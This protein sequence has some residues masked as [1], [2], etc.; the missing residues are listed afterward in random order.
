MRVTTR[1]LAT[2]S[3][4]ALTVVGTAACG[5]SS[6]G[7]NGGGASAASG[8]SITVRGC[9]PQNPLIAGNTSEVCGGNVL[10]AVTAKLVHYNSDTAAPEMD[11]A[12]SID[13]K[14]NKVFTVTLQKGRTFSDG[15]PVTAH[16]FV[17]AWNYTAYGPNAQ[18][19]GYFFEPIAGY[20]KLQC[21]DEKCAK[22]PATTK[23]SGLK[24]IDDTHFTITTAQP[25]S[26]LKVRLGYSA[27]AP[28]PDAFLKNPTAASF[29]K[30]PIGAGPYK[31]TEDSATQIVLQKN[32][33]YTGKYA[34]K[35][36][37][38]TFKIYNDASAAYKDLQANQL[39]FTDIIPTDQL[40]GD[41]WKATLGDR[42]VVAKSGLFQEL[43]FSP[44]DPQLK[45][46]YA[47][48]KALAMDIDRD[49][50][51]KQIFNG[52]R[53]PA[54]GWVSPVVDG[55][56]DGACGDT[57]HYD[58]DK[59]KAAYTAA[60]GY[61]GTMQISVNGDGGH[62]DWAQAVCNGWINDLGMKCVVNLTPDFATLRKQIQGGELKGTFRGGWQMDYPSI[63]NFLTPI[64]AKGAASND[65]KYDNPAFDKKLA[66]AAAA[67]DPAQANADYQ[68][69]EDMLAEQ[70]PTIPLWNAATPCAWSTHVSNVKVTPFGTL[71]LSSITVKG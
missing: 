47:L 4:A 56:K 59:A 70:M 25:V 66:E 11:L 36:D 29:G 71:D 13:T 67:T 58:K 18:Q 27:F 57:C 10:E 30:M 49:T 9:T 20:D 38:V 61:N 17:D 8:G 54:D 3:V 34:G 33:K 46:N 35:V 53:T 14:D 24:V 43:T 62:K 2:V 21:A 16:N 37:Q 51:T 23:M 41:N 28:Q 22:K 15:T 48:R 64:Y 7:S 55:F 31:V 26:N 69:A 68:A 45:T 50:I 60:G 42:T 52:T 12:E 5:G 1:R 19:G 6:N 39:D 44:A 63:E 40:A 32:D 65:A